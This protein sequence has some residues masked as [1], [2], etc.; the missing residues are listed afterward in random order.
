MYRIAGI[1]TTAAIRS[2]AR[3]RAAELLVFLFL[4]VPSMILSFFVIRQGSV[5]FILTAS[6]TILRDLSLVSLIA[7]FLWHNREPPGRI[8][9]TLRNPG[10]EILLGIGLFL[11]LFPASGL[12]ETLFHGL[13]LSGPPMPQPHFLSV[14]GTG[15]T[16]LALV[17][18]V[19]VAVSEEVI[20]R[21]YLIARLREATGS[22]AVAVLVSAFVFSLGHGYEGTAGV[23][24]VGVMG[25]IYALVYLQRRSLVA[26]VT[27]HLLQDLLSIVVLP[28][29]R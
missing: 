14:R 12:M 29:L 18:V 3:Q 6:A 15:E 25:L 23:A 24:T 10:K 1:P 13:G 8:G 21:G 28:Y 20:F 11:L 7:Y 2:N 19:V 5:G 22:S 27:M 16:V 17:L 4:I 9:C 26:P